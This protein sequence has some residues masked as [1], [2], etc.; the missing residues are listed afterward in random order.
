MLDS[1]FLTTIGP[2]RGTH[3]SIEAHALAV[4]TSRERRVLPRFSAMR[5]FSGPL[6]PDTL[7]LI[8]RLPA[9][10]SRYDPVHCA[11]RALEECQ[12]LFRSVR[13]SRSAVGRAHATGQLAHMLADLCD[14][15]H[16]VGR[17]GFERVRIF[18][19]P[20]TEHWIDPLT[21]PIWKRG[22]GHNHFEWLLARTS[23][24]ESP[25]VVHGLIGERRAFFERR[26]RMQSVGV[27]LH[28]AALEIAQTGLWDSFLRGASID[29]LRRPLVDHVIL[30]A[31]GLIAACLSAASYDLLWRG[32]A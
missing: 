23:V 7:W 24:P 5:I 13:T 12:R 25:T 28:E 8:G 20:R 30:P 17:P 1:Y 19:L 2:L 21:G 29:D 15:A 22:E 32:A 4:L 10:C 18:G 6:G 3:D 16:H 9:D 14:P 11:G 27:V 31:C 26:L